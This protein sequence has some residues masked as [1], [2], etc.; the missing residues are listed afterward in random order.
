M[1]KI[2][3]IIF[4][5][6]GVLSSDDDL[7]DIGKF[8]AKKYQLPIK[9]LDD[10]T[11][12]GWK[13]ARLNPKYDPAFWREV[14][15]ALGISEKRLQ[16]EY[17]AFPKYLPEVAELVRKL[18]KRYIIGMLSNQIETWHQPLM[19]RWKLQGLFDPIVTSYGEGIAKPDKRIYRR[20]QKKLGIP[21]KECVYIDDRGYNL[22]P[23][24]ELGMRTV[25]FKT[26]KQLAREL[27]ELGV[28]F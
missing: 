9:V 16:A 27:K 6:G 22:Q 24:E 7:K 11:W 26:P 15:D 12:Q 1:E 19:K 8:L 14:A 20:L 17:L 10:V 13:K 5:F 18:R 4:D 2:S 28:E 23:A 25:L 21:F 3:A